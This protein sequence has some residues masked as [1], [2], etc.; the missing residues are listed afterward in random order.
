ML[1]ANEL[2]VARLMAAGDLVSPHHYKNLWLVCLRIT[3][4]GASFRPQ[5]NEFVFR[6]KE[7]Y[8]TPDFL[9][10][11]GGLP[12]VMYHPKKNI[13][14]SKSYSS[15][16]VGA[17]MLPFIRG[18]EVWAVCRVHDDE[19]AELLQT[20]RMSTS[21]G[22]LIGKDSIKLGLADGSKLL[23]EDKPSLIDHLAVC[24]RGVWDKG[25]DPAGIQQDT[26]ERADSADRPPRPGR[27]D[28]LAGPL[29]ALKAQAMRLDMNVSRR[30]SSRH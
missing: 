3:G 23:I 18:D 7:D 6:Q 17:V 2:D 4:T 21:P 28:R 27:F 19:A 8:L 22:V 24:E 10:R 1:T 5:I 15:S 26:L 11:I 13:L 29:F 14:D 25:G 16:V 12:V 30:R 20:E 9:A